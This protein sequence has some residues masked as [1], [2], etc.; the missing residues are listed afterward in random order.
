MIF[1]PRARAFSSL[2]PASAPA[3][4]KSVVLADAG[5][6]FAAGGLDLGG[7]GLAGKGGERACQDECLA[8]E[9][10]GF[11]GLLAAG[12]E[13]EGGEAGEDAPAGVGGEVIEDAAGDDG[14]DLSVDAGVFHGGFAGGGETGGEEALLDG[15]DFGFI[16]GGVVG[17]DVFEEG[18][19]GE[20]FDG[21]VKTASWP[22]VV[23]PTSGMA[24]AKSQ[25][26]SGAERA[27]SMAWRAFS[28]FFASED[29]R[30]FGGAEVEGGQVVQF[31]LEKVEG[32]LGEAAFDEFV[33]DDAADAFDI[34]GAAGGLKNSRRRV[35]CAGHCRFS[36][37]QATLLGIAP[38]GAVADGAFAAGERDEVKG[39]GVLRAVWRGQRRRRRYDFAGFLDGDGV[40]DADVFA[41]DF[42]FVVRG[43]AGDGAAGE[44]DGIQ[45]GDGCQYSGAATWMWIWL[46]T[47]LGLFGGVFVGHGPAG[48]LAV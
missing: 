28:A 18:R 42:V 19:L 23:L 46:R 7:G 17:D 44:K 4:R 31:N 34:E 35:A 12:A 24:R 45:L 29:A 27:R 13:A 30:V 14:A 40:A 20:V 11:L 33:G 5:G 37:R 22:A 25:R 43:G 36:Q 8:E 21:F 38:D 10:A 26:E 2:E 32:F 39:G 6:D 15:G 16:G 47:G 9:G 48:A 1:T 3:R 41:A